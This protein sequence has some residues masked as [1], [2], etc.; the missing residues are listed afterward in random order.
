MRFIAATNSN[1]IVPKYL[2]SGEFNPRPSLATIAN[3]MDVGNPSNFARIA[4]LYNNA[5]RAI[6]HDVEGFVCT[7]DQIRATIKDVYARRKYL[8]DP[9]GAVGYRALNT[10]LGNHPSDAGFFVE[11]AHPAKFTETVE[12]IID[13]NIVLPPNLARFANGIKK[14]EELPAR[15]E[16][17]KNFLL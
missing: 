8:L 6:C 10:Y 11:T 4:A 17:L 14:T 16:A 9:H 2:Q 3:A 13:E 1:D 5:Y 12:N 7:D 15:F